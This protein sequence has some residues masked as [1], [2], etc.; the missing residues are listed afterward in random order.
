MYPFIRLA[1]GLWHSRAMPPLGLTGTH[2]S[3]HVC[4]P[5]D[6]DPWMELNNGRTLTLYDLGRIPFGRRI[7][8][9]TALRANGWG[10]AVAGAS[11]R[12]RRRI[13]AFHRV[14]MRTRG[15]GWDDRFIYMD[16]SLWRNGDCAN[17]VL[18]RSAV[19]SA[20]GIVA[21]ARLIAAMGRDTAS[22]PLPGWVQAWI[23]ADAERPWP[24]ILPD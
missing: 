18:I 16:Q 14:E 24:P 12:Y 15:L 10:M 9:D 6:I 17:Q 2:V 21:P 11:V 22:P 8:L 4:M 1:A 7:G 5:W 13:R 19:T 23:A 3:H 20:E